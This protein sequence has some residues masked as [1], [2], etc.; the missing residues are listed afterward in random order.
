M[1]RT[2]EHEPAIPTTRTRLSNGIFVA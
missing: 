1:G 2:L